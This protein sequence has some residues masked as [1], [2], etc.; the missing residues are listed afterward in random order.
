MASQMQNR[1]TN[2]ANSGPQANRSVNPDSTNPDIEPSFLQEYY[3]CKTEYQMLE[4]EDSR[5]ISSEGEFNQNKQPYVLNEDQD[6]SEIGRVDPQRNK[7]SKHF[8]TFAYTNEEFKP[9]PRWATSKKNLTKLTKYQ[10]NNLDSNQVFG[11]FDPQVK[12]K[13]NHMNMLSNYR[14]NTSNNMTSFSNN[15]YY[16]NEANQRGSSEKWNDDSEFMSAH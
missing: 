14:P 2:P 3:D 11:K 4:K 1:L 6:A 9:I 7:N 5:A 13:Y 12:K 8:K 10:K 15:S 16:E